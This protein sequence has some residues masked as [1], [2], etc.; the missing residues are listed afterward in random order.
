MEFDEAS[1]E[2]AA[3]ELGTLWRHGAASRDREA[4]EH[5]VASALLDD[6]DVQ[7]ALGIANEAGGEV[8]RDL[9]ALLGLS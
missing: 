2:R 9:V 1:L 4:A 7:R 6:F 5:E 3:A 8:L